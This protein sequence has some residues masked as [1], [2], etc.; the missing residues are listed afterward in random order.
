METIGTQHLL[1]QTDQPG[2]YRVEVFVRYA[3]QKRGWIYSNPIYFEREPE[4]LLEEK[5]EE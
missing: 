2:A 5:G 4:R 1:L 3:G